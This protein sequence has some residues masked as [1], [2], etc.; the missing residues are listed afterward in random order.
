MADRDD[1]SLARIEESSDEGRIAERSAGDE[2]ATHTFGIY[3]YGRGYWVR[4]MTAV[5]LGVLF[6]AGAA[7]AWQQLEA[8]SLPNRAWSVTAT[9]TQGSAG[10][11]NVVTFERMIDGKAEPLGTGVLESVS[12]QGGTSASMV[13][14]NVKMNEGV[15]SPRD[16]NHVS[17]A[18]VAGGTP[19]TGTLERQAVS[20][21]PV[22]QRVYLQLGVA[23]LLV[24]I[25]CGVV[26][27]FVA[28]KPSSVDFL[29]ATDEEMRKV[30]W[31]TRKI[32][33]DSTQV[34]IFA[35]FLIAAYIFVADFLLK[36]SLFDQIVR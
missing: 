33:L 6:L 30:N 23:S 22:F 12:T 17:V 3:K 19:L 26:F 32:I 34:V 28:R 29:I 11:G 15:A 2:R 31:S 13:V 35:T 4:V 25:G 8:L 21:I 7:W 14:A 5:G 16:A 18:P 24:L 36:K 27:N 9:K 1:K 10:V 20:G